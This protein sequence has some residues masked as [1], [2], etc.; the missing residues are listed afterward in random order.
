MDKTRVLALSD[1][2]FAIV[3]T[4]LIFDIKIP[5]FTDMVTDV[6]L[7]NALGIL[8]PHFLV[9][10]GTFAVLSVMWLNH[11]F[12]F[13]T[14]AKEVDRPLNLLNLL[15]LMFIA[16]VPFS[17]SFMGE[18]HAHQPAVVLYGLNLLAVAFVSTFMTA[19]IKKTQGVEH[20][21]DRLLNQ[22]RFR[23]TLNIL[24][25]L[26]ALA[27]SFLNEYAALFFYIFPV[28]FNIIPGTLDFTEKLFRFDLG[29]REAGK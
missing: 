19:Y 18:F 11:H 16:F 26:L 7:W 9:F 21:S 25:Y 28:F 2:V 17:A 22:S 3:M 15:Y 8:W 5:A 20:L 10:A 6:Q 27:V 29:E 23:Y 1:G 13:D 14:F 24:C 12:L 4:L